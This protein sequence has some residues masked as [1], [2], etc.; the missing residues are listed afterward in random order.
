LEYV[1]HTRGGDYKLWWRSEIE[2]RPVSNLP[3]VKASSFKFAYRT[4]IEHFLPS[5]L[6]ER[7]EQA[8]VV[9]TL[10]NRA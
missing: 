4:S 1:R 2:H 8:A 7:A 10:G 9:N 3:R 5:N 6:A